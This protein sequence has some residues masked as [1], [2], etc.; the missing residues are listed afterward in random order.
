[1]RGRDR[2]P[3]ATVLVR[4]QGTRSTLTDALTALAAQR[5]DD[6]EVIVLVH[7]DDGVSRRVAATV[8]EFA[9]AFSVRVRVE[10]VGPGGRG[11][12]LNVGMQL[13]RGRYVGFLDDDDLVTADWIEVF[14]RAAVDQP[15]KVVRARS[16]VQ[17]IEPRRD[18]A[19]DFEVVSGFETAYPESF[20]LLDTIRQNRSPSCSYVVPIDVVD[21][22]GL[23]FDE[24]LR[25]CED[26]RFELE[27]ALSAGVVSVPEVTSIYRRWRDGPHA[28][29]AL[30]SAVGLTDD[31]RYAEHVR[32][33]AA[34]DQR[35]LTL[36]PGSLARIR[37]LYHRI[38]Q[39][40]RA[41]PS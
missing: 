36:P 26:W 6:F 5:C 7:A 31:E 16:V 23:F 34:L 32:V 12:P 41:G 1:V 24:T 30:H 19:A 22:D 40:E 39:L 10:R 17:W 13:A 9:P 33:I 37:E 3:F 18:G 28:G 4:T 20:D 29:D 11:R 21:R 15:G 8:S 35:P 25:V 27:A 2:V 38:E 14:R